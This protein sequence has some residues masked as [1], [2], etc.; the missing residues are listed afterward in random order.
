VRTVGEVPAS[1][2]LVLDLLQDGVKLTAGGR[3]PRALVREAQAWRPHWCWDARLAQQEPDLGPLAARSRKNDVRLELAG[4]S[5]MLRSLDQ[6]EGALFD[7][8]A[9]P[10]ALTLLPRVTGLVAALA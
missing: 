8:S 4:A 9:G 2:R 1:A 7:W 3:L 5:R 10:S 6:I